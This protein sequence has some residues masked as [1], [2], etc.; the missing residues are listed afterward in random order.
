MIIDRVISGDSSNGYILGANLVSPIASAKFLN[1]SSAV[2]KSSA[3]YNEQ[4]PRMTTSSFSL[5]TMLV[6]H[7]F[8]T[9]AA[10]TAA[11]S[12]GGSFF[13]LF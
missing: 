8:A 11:H 9:I 1:Y 4:L 10:D 12:F 2:V 5:F 6:F 13:E 3:F 7:V